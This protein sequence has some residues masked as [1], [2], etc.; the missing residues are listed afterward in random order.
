MGKQPPGA[1]GICRKRRG[2]AGLSAE[3]Y[4]EVLGL[5]RPR[6][7]RCLLHPQP[8]DSSSEKGSE[9]AQVP[10]SGSDSTNPSTLLSAEAGKAF[11]MNRK[12]DSAVIEQRSPQ[13]DPS[14][15]LLCLLKSQQDAALT[16]P[17]P[18]P[19]PSLKTFSRVQEPI[20]Q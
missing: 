4:P 15:R 10:R 7:P 1:V 16:L 18:P 8:R 6:G 9:S 5:R 20:K 2:A 3:L 14:E 17:F 13:G 12:P 11:F 19:L